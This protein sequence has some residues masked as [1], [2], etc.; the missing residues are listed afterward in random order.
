[1]YLC[2]VYER[3]YVVHMDP[4]L[5]SFLCKQKNCD[6]LKH[7]TYRLEYC[8]SLVLVFLHLFCVC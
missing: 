4:S 6:T 8:L 7:E 5:L 1:M 3:T 2:D